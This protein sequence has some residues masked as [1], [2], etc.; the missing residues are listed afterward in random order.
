M[1]ICQRISICIFCP[2]LP[3]ET[4]EGEYSVV[5]YITSD[6]CLVQSGIWRMVP[7]SILEKRVVLGAELEKFCKVGERMIILPAN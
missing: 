7:S 3:A 4:G 2:F 1:R 5:W 6:P